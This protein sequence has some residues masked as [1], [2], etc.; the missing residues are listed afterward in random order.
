[1]GGLVSSLLS[2]SDQQRVPESPSY[3]GYFTEAKI[4]LLNLLHQHQLNYEQ[5]LRVM[6]SSSVGF[7]GTF[8]GLDR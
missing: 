7:Q 3:H 8:L 4:L 5:L 6:Q 1:V 2:C